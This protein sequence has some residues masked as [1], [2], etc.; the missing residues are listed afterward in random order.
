M[1]NFSRFSPDYTSFFINLRWKLVLLFLSNFLLWSSNVRFCNNHRNEKK[2]TTI[3]TT[4]LNLSNDR[5]T[6]VW[7]NSYWQWLGLL[8]PKQFGLLKWQWPVLEKRDTSFQS[9]HIHIHDDRS[10]K[11]TIFVFTLLISRWP[12]LEKAS[13]VLSSHFHFHNE[14]NW[15][16]RTLLC[17]HP[18][19]FME[20]VF[21]QITGIDWDKALP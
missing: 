5:K 16:K 17:L 7:F 10:W 21:K 20:L 13:I 4:H 19:T 11:T 6:K 9:S 1:M 12:E 14:W 18:F 15:K 3:W 2:A 8:S